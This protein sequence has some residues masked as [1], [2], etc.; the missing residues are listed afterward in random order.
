MRDDRRQGGRK[1]DKRLHSGQA[2][3]WMGGWV[4]EWVDGC[5]C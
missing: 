5:V 2:D 4:P 3:T 1:G